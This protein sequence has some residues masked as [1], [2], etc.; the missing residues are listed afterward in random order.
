M[1]G[2][3]VTR[4]TLEKPATVRRATRADEMAVFELLTDL[5]RHNARGWNF[6]YRP[7]LVLTCIECATRPGPEDRTD[8]KNERRG[9][10]GVIDGPDGKLLGS[11]GLF[12]DPPMWYTAELVPCELWLYVRPGVRGARRLER[13]LARF[14]EWVHESLRP[15]D[16]PIPFPLL[17]GFMHKGPH[18]A[19]MARLWGRLFRGAK[20]CGMLYWRD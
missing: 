4:V 12:L 2:A 11:V 10:I 16:H 6:P 1:T 13:D 5:H 3:E 7:E 14:A 8:P 20:P 17:T 15:K 18:F 19:G 9:V